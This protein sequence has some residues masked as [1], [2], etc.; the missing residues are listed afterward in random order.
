MNPRRASASVLLLVSACLLAWPRLIFAQN[1]NETVGFQSTHAF[2][3]GHFGENIDVLN[4]GLH[5]T[6]PIGP[7]YQ[8][9]DRLGYQ[10]VL[11]YN[12]KVWDYSQFE[13]TSTSVYPYNESPTGI[14]FTLN[15][16]RLIQDT[17]LRPCTSSDCSTTSDCKMR[18]W[19]WVTPDGN[20]HDVWSMED[21]GGMTAPGV[22]NDDT[23]P[24]VTTDTTYVRVNTPGND[25]RTS[26][27]PAGETPEDPNCF[28]VKTP[29][30][31]V[32]TLGHHISYPEPVLANTYRQ[33]N[34]S[35]G[36]W[37][38]T[39][40]EDRS[41]GTRDA[42]GLYPVNVRIEY[43]ARP[44]FEHVIKSIKDAYNREIL[45]TNCK[46]DATGAC[47]RLATS[48]DK[49]S[50][51]TIDNR[52]PIATCQI[53]LPAF[54]GLNGATPIET[55]TSLTSSY[56]FTY[57][58]TSITDTNV[59]YPNSTQTDGPV[60]ELT[61]LDYP[62]Y[63]HRNGT[64]ETYSLYFAYTG[65]D[66]T[67]PNRGE[68]SCRTLP[69]SLDTSRTCYTYPG[70]VKF[71]YLYDYYR[72]AGMYLT[73]AKDAG[74][75][76]G[77][78]HSN[79]PSVNGASRQVVSK[80]IFGLGGNTY[81]WAY[82]RQAE[83]GFTNP[84]VVTV[85]D[86]GATVDCLATTPTPQ[87]NDTV[88]Y[89]HATQPAT[90]CVSAQ[91]NGSQPDDG[92]A[93]DWDDG[94]N[95]R[96]EYFRG[97]GSTRQL[98]RSEEMEHE[99]DPSSLLFQGSTQYHK[100]N[101]RE[102][103]KVIVYNDDGGTETVT[104][105]ADWDSF[106]N[107]RSTSETGFDVPGTRN[108]H[109]AFFA[110]VPS[111]SAGVYMT[112]LAD[113][114]EVHDGQRVLK[115][116]DNDFSLTTGRL[117]FR[118][119]RKTLPVSIGRPKDTTTLSSGDVKTS[120]TYDSQTGSI[121]S[122]TM[123]Q[124]DDQSGSLVNEYCIDYTWNLGAYLK[125]KTFKNCATGTPM[126][127]KA[128][129]RMRDGNTG[130]I[131]STKDSAE[132]ETRYAYDALG[133]LTD[134]TPQGGDF[135]TAVDYVNLLETTVT[136]GLGT[137]YVFSRYQYDGL[138][139][140]IREERLPA[141]PIGG[142]PYRTTCYDIENRVTFKSEWMKPGVYSGPDPCDRNVF[143]GTSFDY[144]TP[145]DPFGRVGQTTTADN[146]TTTTT[147][148]G[149]DTTVTVNNVMGAGS[150]GGTGSVTTIYRRDGWGRLLM[151]DAPSE[152]RCDTWGAS[153]TKDADCNPPGQ[154]TH[155]CAAT[156]AA[157]AF[158]QYDLLDNLVQVDLVDQST[159][160]RQSR[161]FEYDALNHL[162]SVFNPE[163][164]SSV[165]TDYDALG[166]VRT[167]IDASGTRLRFTYDAAGRLTRVE[168]LGSTTTILAENTYDSGFYAGYLAKGKLTSS[169]VRRD[170]Q[171]IVL[172][173]FYTWA[174]ANGRL[175]SF[176]YK[177]NEWPSIDEEVFTYDELGNVSIIDYMSNGAA[178][179]GAV[180]RI[181]YNSSNGIPVAVTD[182]LGNVLASVTYNPAGGVESVTTLGGARTQVV[183]D[184]RNRPSDIT[185]GR[186]SGGSFQGTP[187]Y[188]TNQ[189][190]Y[191]GA[192][193]IYQMAVPGSGPVKNRYSYDSANRLKEAYE[194]EGGVNYMQCFAYDAFGNMI[195]KVDKSGVSITD[196]CQ[197]PLGMTWDD[198]FTVT[199]PTSGANTNR[200]IS[201]QVAGG[202][203]LATLLYDPK[204]NL[205][206]DWE[207]RYLYDS[208][209]RMSSVFRLSNFQDSTSAVSELARYDYGD[210]GHRVIKRDL[211]RDLTTYYFRDPDGQL[212]M[213]WR[214]TA[215]GTYVP[216]W[217]KQHVYLAGREVGF[218]DNKIP[219]PPGRLTVT[220]ARHGSSS[221]VK[222][223]W[224]KNPSE[225][226]VTSY[227]I[228]RATS[229]G[230]MVSV[231]STNGNCTPDD[232]NSICYIESVASDTT[233]DYQ[234][235]AQAGTLVSYGSDIVNFVSGD[236]DATN[237]PTCLQLT[238]GDR[239]VTLSWTA[240]TGE[241]PQGYSVWRSTSSSGQKVR[242]TQTLVPEK[243][244]TDAGLV[245]GTTYYYS[246]KAVDMVG[247]VSG[248]IVNT[249]CSSFSTSAQPKDYAAPGPPMN[250]VVSGDCNAAGTATLSWDPNPD[251]DQ[252]TSYQVY[253]KKSNGSTEGP[254]AS[255][256]DT[257]TN[258]PK[259]NYNDTGLI[260][261][262][263]YYYWVV[264]QDGA[265]NNSV[266]SQRV[267]VA[268]RASSLPVPS[269]K[270]IVTA[271]D[272]QVS[273]RFTRPT[274]ST[275]V[276]SFVI[277]RK[278]NAELSCGTYQQVGQISSQGSTC[279]NNPVACTQDSQC[280]A[281]TCNEN[282]GSTTFDY[283][284]GT[285][286]N[287]MAWDYAVASR[288]R[289]LNES[290][291]SETA[292]AIPVAAPKDLRECVEEVPSS[293]ATEWT[294]CVCT[295][296]PTTCRNHVIRWDPPP[297]KPYHP[298]TATNAD[299]T[300]G[301]LLGYHEKRYTFH[302]QGVSGNSNAAMDKST[303][304]EQN[305]SF[306]GS[307]LR[308]NCSQWW[309]PGSCTP[310]SNTCGD[311]DTCVPLGTCTKDGSVS[312]TTTP[313][314]AGTTCVK[315]CSTSGATCTTNQDCQG[316]QQCLGYC[317]LPT[318]L[319][320]HKADCPATAS[321]N[322][323][324]GTVDD[325]NGFLT[326]EDPYLLQT[327]GP[328]LVY[329]FQISMGSNC[330][331]IASV[332]KV[333]VNGDWMTVTSQPSAN[334]D[335][336]KTSAAPE[337][338]GYRCLQ[339]AF[340]VCSPTAPVC[341]PTTEPPEIASPQATTLDGS[342][343]QI[344]GR[345][346]VTWSAPPNP[347]DQAKVAGY[348][349]YVKEEK[350][351]GGTTPP[352]PY[353]F[354]RPTPFITL[355]PSQTSYEFTTLPREGR[356][357]DG[358]TTSPTIAY[359]FQVAAFDTQGRVGK[360][361]P[362]SPSATVFDDSTIARPAWGLK[363][364]IWSVNDASSDGPGGA[365]FQG[366]L[367][368][369]PRSY[370]GIKLQWKSGKWM[371]LVGFRVYRSET[372]DGEYCALVQ[373]GGAALDAPV[374][375]DPANKN[376]LYSVSLTHSAT[377]AGN[378]RFFHD[379]AVTPG[380]TYYYKVKSIGDSVSPTSETA[381]S[382][383]V[384]G[385]VLNHPAQPLSP[386]RHFKAW[387]PR[388]KTQIQASPPAYEWRVGAGVYLRW[389]PNRP[390]E[391]VTGYN[392][393]RSS[394]SGGPYQKIATLTNPVNKGDDCLLGSKR[395]T[396]CCGPPPCTAAP[397]CTTAP[398]ADPVA[399]L[400][401]V[402][403]TCKLVDIGVQ[404]PN[405][406]D[407]PG[408]QASK[409]Y[410]YVV[411]AQRGND[412]SAYSQENTAWPNYCVTNPSGACTNIYIERYDQDNFG[413]F[414]CDDETSAIQRPDDAIAYLAS[415]ASHSGAEDR[416]PGDPFEKVTGLDSMSPY[417]IIGIRKGSG[418]GG[419]GST[420][421]QPIGRWFFLHTDH[422]GSPRVIVDDLGNKISTHHYMP[423]GEEKPL[424]GRLTSN[425]RKFTGHERDVE[426]SSFDNP[427]G[428][429]YMFARYY[430]ASLG[431]FM[432]VDP[433]QSVSKEN[434]QTWNRYS[435]VLNNPLKF[436]DPTGERYTSFDVAFGSGLLRLAMSG[437]ATADRTL[438]QFQRNPLSVWGKVDPG[439]R[440]RVLNASGSEVGRIYKR[441][442]SLP[443]AAE[444]SKYVGGV[445]LSP[446][447]GEQKNF[448]GTGHDADVIVYAGSQ[449]WSSLKYLSAD[450]YVE[451]VILHETTHYTANTDREDIPNAAEAAYR[452]EKY[453]AQGSSSRPWSQGDPL[454]E[455]QSY[456]QS[457]SNRL[458]AVMQAERSA[459]AE[460]FRN[461]WVK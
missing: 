378:N 40:I 351:D 202:S 303:F 245:N 435:Y 395:C 281:G 350:S 87:C 322:R 291:M 6:V 297:T 288:D 186:W 224:K 410:Y 78:F 369:N 49:Y 249:G 371:G 74:L 399:C 198:I 401:G 80:K 28:T 162:Y 159:N 432:A 217:V 336:T 145:P 211:L 400:V 127:W 119:E 178:I 440:F 19:K 348:Y 100:S 53:D 280:G 247:N 262:S 264:A 287:N 144:G 285:V 275:K 94:L 305:L 429:D 153:C 45:F 166:N 187:Y 340:D 111:T 21:H 194:T 315:T 260:P 31:L 132:V 184:K 172:Q 398:T 396:I 115:R 175:S 270:L 118:I 22:N 18:T 188:E 313:C 384:A 447:P 190:Y 107:W 134:I 120:I 8:V 197:G 306:N 236:S 397:P 268:Q 102:R 298:L 207:R 443:T 430:S 437:S 365:L 138:G 392:V 419:G 38:V 266:S 179:P 91:Q 311:W 73:G 427:D 345:L 66:G 147:Y 228:Y 193:N 183:P 70:A 124:W 263:I 191:D 314:A 238:A 55:V 379:K 60:L 98:I 407:S 231:G 375:P 329:P 171:S 330:V 376:T 11:H 51:T 241:V 240:P 92:L 58:F 282:W 301:Y 312:C 50:G 63:T 255:G 434:P 195:G 72:Y 218:R 129:D 307:E 176:I 259:T 457:F 364:E 180:A 37:Y 450:E 4:G 272:G 215:L 16:G 46:C 42:S 223:Q 79:G 151:V 84:R 76:K 177:F 310:G 389:C 283:T 300:L 56:K 27:L 142:N 320:L 26:N 95:Y 388:V 17:Q 212:L 428:L 97:S 250:L 261:G 227:G 52:H 366:T 448:N 125:S 65:L 208:R 361:S 161:F 417:R 201:E 143:P 323:G 403:G 253:R 421:P 302:S 436:L 133:R 363:T 411:T 273:V 444:V 265:G 30:G 252:V 230:A 160:R 292:L 452:S 353:G 357:Y 332:Y 425:N 96:V 83:V 296:P 199:D 277:Y 140:L 405:D 327:P 44:G 328:R 416:G 415:G 374:C 200:V 267:G 234:V 404:Q 221:D 62:S 36:G 431:R 158:Y 344:P 380:V 338:A 381:F 29:D 445:S 32:Y 319:C 239:Q 438:V 278:P 103:R 271:G 15:L 293:V 10:L 39:R 342:G 203:G 360:A 402:G 25:C 123:G 385:M 356:G 294:T 156:D 170:D 7:S 86:K 317:S 347:T 47:N 433:G 59:S 35:F 69:L 325:L 454:F 244:Y 229:G 216:E 295:L 131:F 204:G 174:E 185:I 441:E 256:I 284:D 326:P 243:N 122:K 141:D 331:T 237:P 88:Y 213:E 34:L 391:Q 3:S 108:T 2:E 154:N 148:Q 225:E 333:S 458:G 219:S 164:G 394:S 181:Y 334:F 372:R 222:L 41:V 33:D 308:Y 126:T 64:P 368:L 85:T 24:I 104:S 420:T 43:D 406:T 442:G 82:A 248:D 206:K 106:G 110:I 373:S 163:S 57:S 324:R 460:R 409:V 226:A 220:T 112:G 341:Q 456:V 90:Q 418:G 358:G 382:E 337:S 152:K 316:S 309:N 9:N 414:G 461:G 235:V 81:E 109:S 289:N 449:K 167:T 168:K 155:K 251:T 279:S 5:L 23:Y 439:A 196:T 359:R 20:Q 370:D 233:F 446:L 339:W 67:S 54:T 413:D 192:G 412:E 242:I 377:E 130:A 424:P 383:I 137:N 299:G 362:L 101:I 387:A 343:H 355:G 136:R 157:D 135:A 349:L 121:T 318:T 113:Y 169:T 232:P 459:L 455:L 13:E 149:K 93:P 352:P 276:K 68:L 286:T 423:F 99:A 71:I 393:Y 209:N 346:T 61:R 254:W 274:D 367:Y 290:A 386:P 304:T 453:Q 12:S 182:H 77:N 173:K 48:A 422:L 75:T 408:D 14:G 114:T 1:E 246:V 269:E 189:Y 335:L 257:L 146:Q 258:K 451:S 117:N 210:D 128:I 116:T 205:T 354:R 165:S 321:C 390:E 139:R 214:R 426:S 105:H 150:M 89:Y